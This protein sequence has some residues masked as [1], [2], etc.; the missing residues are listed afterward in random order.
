MKMR[1][2]VKCSLKH[3]EDMGNDKLMHLVFNLRVTYWKRQ[4]V[5]AERS[6]RGPEARCE[7]RVHKLVWKQCTCERK[8]PVG[9]I[10]KEES[11]R[12]GNQLFLFPWM[13]ESEHFV[14]PSLGKK[15][16]ND[17]IDTK[18]NRWQP[19]GGETRDLRCSHVTRCGR[20]L[21]CLAFSNFENGILRR[22]DWTQMVERMKGIH[23]IF[24]INWKPWLICLVPAQIRDSLP[25]I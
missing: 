22:C 5:K 2:Q 14:C 8:H 19:G 18:V 1:K 10:T 12:L 17:S 21:L 25:R 11:T 9:Y 16:N 7:E 13:E 3:S 4:R 15:E 6:R 23:W 20:H 24:F